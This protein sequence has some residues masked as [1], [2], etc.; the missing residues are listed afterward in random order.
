MSI[1]LLHLDLMRLVSPYDCKLEEGLWC[2]IMS[3][4]YQSYLAILILLLLLFKG[5]RVSDDNNLW[6]ETYPYLVVEFLQS[7]RL[8]KIFVS[9]Q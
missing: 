7:M 1:N 9:G 5:F 8:L 6:K 2:H 3:D 4:K